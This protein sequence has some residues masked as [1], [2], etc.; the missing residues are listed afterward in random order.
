MFGSLAR[1]EQLSSSDV[2][3]MLVGSLGFADAVRVLH[4]VQETLQREINPVVYTLDEFQ[5]RITI[6]DSFI[7]EILSKPKLFIVGNENEL[8]K[9]TQDQTASAA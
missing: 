1:G 9:L 7:Q 6:G 2:D 3:V 8:R 5:R 4:P